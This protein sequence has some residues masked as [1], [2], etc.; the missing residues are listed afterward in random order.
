MRVVCLVVLLGVLS[1]CATSGS[2]VKEYN[3]LAVFDADMGHA[4]AANVVADMSRYCDS[5]IFKVEK[6]NLESI[7]KSV[8]D[9]KNENA[10]HYYLHVEFTQDES[11][12]SKVSVF[13]VMDTEVTRGMADAIRQ[14]V[15][16][17][18][19][20]CVQGF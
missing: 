17:G 6:K 15:T 19:T 12:G 16:E 13:H 11:G 10:D 20:E 18:S 8:V 9:L 4:E 1:G 3:L 7:N 14:W 2:G 5:G